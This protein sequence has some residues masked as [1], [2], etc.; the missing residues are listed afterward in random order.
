VGITAESIVFL[1]FSGIT[2]CGALLVVL[3]RNL[4]HAGL[5]LMVSL[6]GVAGLFALLAAPFLAGAQVLIYIGAIAILIILAIML[7]PGI[8]QMKRL[9]NDQ[10]PVNAALAAIFFILLVT[11]L[12]PLMGELGADNWAAPNIGERH[13][14]GV[15]ANSIEHLGQQLVSRVGYM[16][17]FEVA[18]ILLMAAMIGAVLLVSPSKSEDEPGADAD[19]EVG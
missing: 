18:S 10:W 7:T 4:F 8:T 19:Q 14:V 15:P 1:I 9:F 17:P 16:L 2:L 12:S 13:P 6:F 5:Y 3:S 11:V